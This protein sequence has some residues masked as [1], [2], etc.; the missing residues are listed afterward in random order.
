MTGLNLTQIT[1]V[2]GE[3]VAIVL[4]ADR[5]VFLPWDALFDAEQDALLFV[6]RYLHAGLFALGL[7]LH[8]D[9]GACLAARSVRRHAPLERV[10]ALRDAALS[11]APH[12]VASASPAPAGKLLTHPRPPG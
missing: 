5:R 1:D 10:R 11:A 7:R 8:V 6:A 3:H 2:H 12:P 9:A 4:A